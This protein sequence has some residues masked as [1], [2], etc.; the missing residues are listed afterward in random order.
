M[1][2]LDQ[3]NRYIEFLKADTTECEGAELISYGRTR[4]LRVD[5]KLNLVTEINRIE[6]QHGLPITRIKYV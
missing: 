1:A 6:R 5:E 2:E 4:K 3:L